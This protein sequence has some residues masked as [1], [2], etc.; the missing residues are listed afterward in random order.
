VAVD[1]KIVLLVVEHLRL[2]YNVE[3]ESEASFCWDVVEDWP[4]ERIPQRELIR[5]ELY[6]REVPDFVNLMMNKGSSENKRRTNR[7][8]KP[9]QASEK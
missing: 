1:L 4:V 9:S 2:L 6:S 8:F 7:K 5:E 3:A